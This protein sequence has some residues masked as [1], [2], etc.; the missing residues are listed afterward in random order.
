MCSFFPKLVAGLR[1]KHLVTRIWERV[2]LLFPTS[3]I[4]ATSPSRFAQLDRSV[5]IR[6]ATNINIYTLT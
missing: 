4:Q 6:K 3:N 1:L 2:P 5:Q